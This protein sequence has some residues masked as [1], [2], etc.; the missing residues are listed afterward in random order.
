MSRISHRPP[1]AARKSHA[2]PKADTKT[3]APKKRVSEVRID[4]S[5]YDKAKAAK[6]GISLS[7]SPT[8]PLLLLKGLRDLPLDN[9]VRSALD[10]TRGTIPE[11]H[12]Q[13]VSI[14]THVDGYT[15]VGVHAYDAG[16][17]QA[18]RTFMDA[19]GQVRKDDAFKMS[20][21]GTFAFVDD[22]SKARVSLKDA[23]DK[24]MANLPH[25]RFNN[26]AVTA[27]KEGRT[28]YNFWHSADWAIEPRA[29]VD[30]MTGR[31]SII[32]PDPKTF[33]DKTL[34]VVD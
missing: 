28:V 8:I 23:I 21:P 29:Q 30:V 6:L 11:P 22:Y 18:M 33:E 4:V 7:P 12:L 9:L 15:Q 34:K 3:A 17:T 20:R 5:Q 10:R 19:T 1:A 2:A 31:L 24:V 26:I 14:G 27:D 32:G 13:Q 16:Q 25:G